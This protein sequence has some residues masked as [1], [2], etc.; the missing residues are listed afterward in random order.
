MKKLIT[1]CFLVAVGLVLVTATVMAAPSPAEVEKKKREA[2]LHL[3]GKVTADE[4]FK[5]ISQ[6]EQY[7]Q[8]VRRMDLK[9]DRLIKS[10]DGEKVQSIIEVFYWYIPSWQAKEYTG[11]ARMD[12]AVGDVIEIWL[13]DGEYGLQPALG[14]NTVKHIKYTEVRNEPIPEPFLNLLQRKVSSYLMEY[15]EIIVLFI[16]SLIL[17]LI[18]ILANK[19]TKI[20]N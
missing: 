7:P 18:F 6:N 2:P 16:L 15:I 14:G 13:T 11:G 3:I 1:F 4:I 17:L 12:I 8:Q 9:V 20:V 19:S 5:D 10:P